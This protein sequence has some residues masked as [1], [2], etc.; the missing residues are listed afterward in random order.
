MTREP[1]QKLWRSRWYNALQGLLIMLGLALLLAVPGW[2]LAGPAGVFWALG[3]VLLAALAG[4]RMPA[5]LILARSGAGHLPR[6]HAPELYTILDEL[7]RRAG[8]ETEPALYYVP[9][10][11]LNAFSVGDRKDGGLAI[12]DGLLRVLNLRQLAG[13]LAH[14]VSHLS[15]GDTRVMSMAAVVTE[16]T[17]WG[18]LFVQLLLLLLLPFV[19]LGEVDLPWLALLFAAFAPLLSNLLQLALSRNREFTAD[20]EAAALTGDPEGL[21]SA[22]ARLEHFNSRWLA[23]VFG[24]STRTLPG[25]LRT[26]PVTAERV[27][28]LLA[29]SPRQDGARSRLD[30]PPGPV[31]RHRPGPAPKSWVFRLR[32]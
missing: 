10:G 18:A 5:R 32:N 3:L 19:L 13:I 21:A 1:Q 4:G 17:A 30:L 16:L 25:W 2:L 14:E 15:N 12:S 26:H 22:L 7:Y 29:L 11:E 23:S 8:C 31:L 20:L 28:R 9:S 24:H 6:A 27:R